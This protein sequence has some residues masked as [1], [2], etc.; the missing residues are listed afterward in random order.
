M[1]LNL[2]WVPLSLY[3]IILRFIHD[4]GLATYTSF[5]EDYQRH[6]DHYAAPGSH[7]NSAPP[8]D[9]CPSCVIMEEDIQRMQWQF[10]SRRPKNNDKGKERP[11]ETPGIIFNGKAYHVFDFI[12]YRAEKGPSHIGQIIDMQAPPRSTGRTSMNLKVKKVGRI[13]DLVEKVVDPEE[14]I[15]DEVCPLPAQIPVVGNN[16]SYR[17]RDMFS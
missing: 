9:H 10:E 14:A 16:A 12:L 13:W 17:S 4:K 3:P 7:T 11:N 2:P 1:P 5:D 8:L 15:K 6:L